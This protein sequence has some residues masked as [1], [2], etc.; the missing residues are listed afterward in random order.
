MWSDSLYS[1]P[2]GFEYE[3][4][5][6]NSADVL[7]DR[8]DLWFSLDFEWSFSAPMWFR[9]YVESNPLSGPCSWVRRQQKGQLGF[10]WPEAP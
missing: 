6:R 10:L 1:T 5:W 4:P 9:T 8:G 2:G 7:W 3:V